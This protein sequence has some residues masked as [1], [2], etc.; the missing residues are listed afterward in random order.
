MNTIRCNKYTLTSQWR[1]FLT[2]YHHPCRYT[3]SSYSDLATDAQNDGDDILF[4]L[5]TDSWNRGTSPD[6]LDHEIKY[7]KY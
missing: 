6:K 5:S 2:F 1:L 4:K 3:L 7:L